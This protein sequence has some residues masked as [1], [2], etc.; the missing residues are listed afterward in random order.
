MLNLLVLVMT[1]L[2]GTG[3]IPNST[4]DR[5]AVSG[6]ERIHE[7]GL[8]AMELEFVYQIWLNKVQALRI[9]ET[10]KENKVALTCHGSYYINL[11]SPDKKKYHASISRILKAAEIAY[12]AGA[13]SVTF[14]PGYYQK[15]TPEETYAKIKEALLKITD[16]LK[17]KKIDIRVSLETTGKHSQFGS[18]QEILKLSKEIKQVWPCIDFAH[19][20]ARAM[21]KLNTNKEFDKIFKEV[22]SYLG[23]KGLKD[24][25]MHVSG[26]NYSAKG[27][28]NHLTLRES[29]FKIK[30]LIRSF[31][32]NKVSGI[33]VCESPSLEIDADYMKK[34]YFA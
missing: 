6:I 34:L 30:Q 29:D 1:I 15:S 17:R 27:E 25:H 18:L 20:H 12:Y 4:K 24:L 10:A 33:L 8:D 11:N 3:G 22:K 28:L 9:R 2:F 31:K 21:G 32:D 13:H 19:L 7:L 26:I 16:E 14:H 23:N 5:N